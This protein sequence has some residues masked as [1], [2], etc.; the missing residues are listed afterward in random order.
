[1]TFKEYAKINVDKMLQGSP[2]A[3][4]MRDVALLS[5]WL[6]FEDSEYNSQPEIKNAVQ[7]KSEQQTKELND[8]FPAY[9]EFINAKKRYRRGEIDKQALLKI[10]SFLIKE[11]KDFLQSLYSSTDFEEERQQ[12][13]EIYKSR[14]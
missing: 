4:N 5:L 14:P 6:R 8:T 3:Q 9:S 2:T 1:M 7:T 11:I 13:N 10:H 12:L